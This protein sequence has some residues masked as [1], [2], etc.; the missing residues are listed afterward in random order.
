MLDEMLDSAIESVRRT[1]CPR[2]ASIG[3]P[4]Y[5]N[6]DDLSFGASGLWGFRECT[7]AAC[8]L[9]WLDPYPAER[10]ISKAYRSYYTHHASTHRAA[11]RLRFG[12]LL[13]RAVWQRRLGYESGLPYL[14]ALGLECIAYLTP[15]GL[16][17]FLGQAMFLPAPDVPVQLLDVGCGNGELLAQMRGLGWLVSGLD[18][19]HHA[20]SAARDRGLDVI[21][22]GI[23]ELQHR[24][25]SYSAIH[26]S[27]VVE[28]LYDPEIA[29][30]RCFDLLLPGGFLVVVT[31]NVLSLGRKVF[32]RD[33]R[34]LEPPRHLHLFRPSNLG[35]VIG[36]AGFKVETLRTSSKM[37][38]AIVNASYAIRSHR[39]QMATPN[40][41]QREFSRAFA[42]LFQIVERVRLVAEPDA[43]EEIILIGR[44]PVEAEQLGKN[45]S[46][47]GT[48]PATPMRCE[49]GPTP[50]DAIR[51][52]AR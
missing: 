36:E 33:W 30:R 51:C 15:S 31:P 40:R 42:L 8:G 29:L 14:L 27:H 5:D 3:S 6:L 23:D 37:A 18:F 52:V 49:A 43:G 26:L 4:L 16:D 28:H 19:D 32:G 39:R 9:V 7:S 44:K 24:P 50:N 17:A 41:L 47:L 21:E 1:T 10:D 46:V 20:V 13:R 38:R 25:A 48:T 2:C 12:A 35:A 11:W 34:G 22:G 45:V